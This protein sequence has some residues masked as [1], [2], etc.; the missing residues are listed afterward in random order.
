[1]PELPPVIN[2]TFSFKAFVTA[3]PFLA[4]WRLAEVWQL[5]GCFGA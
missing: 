3:P 4:L 2:A 5:A 1:M